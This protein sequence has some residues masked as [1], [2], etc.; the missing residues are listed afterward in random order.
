ML[1]G[2]MSGPV[3]RF[4]L[5]VLG[6]QE[7]RQSFSKLQRGSDHQ[8][9]RRNIV[10]VQ[11]STKNT[12]FDASMLDVMKPSGTARSRLSFGSG[13]RSFGLLTRWQLAS[14]PDLSVHD[15]LDPSPCSRL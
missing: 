5:S 8:G 7:D 15:C 11:R 6:D 2:E 12:P 3:A 9:C 4:A 14:G 1:L 13:G 10:I